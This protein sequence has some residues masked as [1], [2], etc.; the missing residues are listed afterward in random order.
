MVHTQVSWSSTSRY[1][2]LA[3]LH[4]FCRD[5]G[6][7]SCIHLISR[8]FAP[9]LPEKV[10]VKVTQSC[11]T[12]CDPIN[13]TV[14]EI[15]QARILEGGAFP[16]SRASSQ[17]KDGTRV[18]SIA[19]GFFTNWATRNT[20]VGSL[21]LLQGIFPTQECNQGFR[22]LLHRRRILYQLKLAE[23]PAVQ[24]QTCSQPMAG[25]LQPRGL[26]PPGEAWTAACWARGR[27]WG[28]LAAAHSSPRPSR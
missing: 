28:E 3:L 27:C 4:E 9:S 21:S 26:T 22:G 18:S 6:L 8:Y 14:P 2:V 7:V 17:P 12:L 11:P 25:W 10:K 15:L 24:A 16:F 23:K 20:G 5:F 13:Y 1:Q 19:G